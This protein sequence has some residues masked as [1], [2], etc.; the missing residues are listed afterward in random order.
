MVTIYLDKQVFSHLFKGNEEKYRQ[1]REKIYKHRDEFIF[2]YS[3]GHILDLQ[4]DT[5]DI[6]FKELEFIKSIVGNHCLIYHSPYIQVATIEP[7]KAFE[8]RP[9]FF[10]TKWIEDL[11]WD[12]LMKDQSKHSVK[13]V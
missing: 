6:K 12:N 5:T 7:A 1:L 3:E 8:D 10:D 13:Y 11:D 4:N 9:D 2:L